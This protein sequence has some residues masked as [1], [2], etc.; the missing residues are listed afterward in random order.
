MQN[1]IQISAWNYR[2]ASDLPTWFVDLCDV[3]NYTLAYRLSFYCSENLN[4]MVL[5]GG[6]ENFCVTSSTRGSLWAEGLQSFIFGS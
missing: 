4:I 5:K 2:W 6:T 3:R 1:P